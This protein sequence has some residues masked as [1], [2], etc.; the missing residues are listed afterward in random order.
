MKWRV[1][2]VD[3]RV[4]RLAGEDLG[5]IG[6]LNATSTFRLGATYYFTPAFWRSSEVN[7]HTTGRISIWIRRR[8]RQST[9]NALETKEILCFFYLIMVIK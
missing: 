1:W 7:L 9:D 3:H 4:I 2:I 6:Y 8:S 5:S